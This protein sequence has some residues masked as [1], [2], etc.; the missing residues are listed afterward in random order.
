M[1]RGFI[2]G[3]WGIFDQSHRIKARRFRVDNNIKEALA[4]PHSPESKTYVFGK[5]NYDGLVKLGVNNLHLLQNEEFKFDLIKHQYRHKLELIQY[6]MEKD[7]YDEIIYLDWDCYPTK[8]IPSDI[9][10]T[11]AK[12]ESIQANLICYHRVK[13]PWRNEDRRKLP[14]GGFLYIRDK[15]LPSKAIAH[16]DKIPQD[17]DE[18][19]WAKVVEDLM[20]GTWKGMQEYWDRFEPMMCNLHK[21]SPF[22]GEPCYRSKN[23]CFIHRQGAGK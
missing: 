18:I 16:W 22:E 12:K 10:D 11:L 9:W 7:G 19:A 3:V 5:E 2:R 6:A 23:I 21:S 14:N 15:T 20:G 8:Q 17:N 13:C 4:N 1:K